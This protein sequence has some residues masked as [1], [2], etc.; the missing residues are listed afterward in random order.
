VEECWQ[1]CAV[2]MHGRPCKRIVGSKGWPLRDHRMWTCPVFQSVAVDICIQT[3]RIS[4]HCEHK[5]N[6]KRVGSFVCVY[7][8][9]S[10]ACGIYGYIYNRQF[11][12]DYSEIHV[13]V[14]HAVQDSV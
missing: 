6:W 8:H 10:G 7:G 2:A 5:A 1:V 13:L 9:F 3:H 14:R 12:D 11:P 4:W